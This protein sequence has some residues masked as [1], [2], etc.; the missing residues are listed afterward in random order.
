MNRY[1]VPTLTLAVVVP[2]LFGQAANP[3]VALSP[4]FEVAVIRQ[5]DP[6]AQGKYGGMRGRQFYASN[7]TLTYMISFAYGV[8]PNQIT[9]G[10]AWLDADR[11]DLVATPNT[12]NEPTLEQLRVMMQKLLAERFRLSFHNVRKP[13]DIY[14][15]ALGSRPPKLAPS[16]K[17]PDELPKITFNYGTIKA[18]NAMLKDL[19]ATLQSNVLDRPVRDDTALAGRFDFTLTWT[20]DEFQYGGRRANAQAGDG[21]TIFTAYQEQLGLQLRFAKAPTDVMN[22]D[23]VDKPTEN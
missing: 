11:F 21:P 9:G 6:A 15:L 8:H 2:A 1:I 14:V 10:P 3:P 12:P 23:R 16:S 17:P 5:T 13:L 19:A 20:P 4:T 7:V 18:T 22:I